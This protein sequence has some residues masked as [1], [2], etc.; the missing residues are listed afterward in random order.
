MKIHRP[1]RK[2]SVQLPCTA[3]YCRIHRLGRKLFRLRSQILKFLGSFRYRKSANFLGCASPQIKK[4]R[5]FSW[6]V[7]KFLQKMHNSVSPQIFGFVTCGTYLRTTYLAVYTMYIIKHESPK[8][9]MP[10]HCIKKLIFHTIFAWQSKCV[11]SFGTLPKFW[12]FPGSLLTFPNRT[13]HFQHF[14]VFI[15]LWPLLSS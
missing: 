2:V 7:R 5:K 9:L 8:N 15:L 6:F 3:K 14:Y 11:L 13:S 1:W 12:L 4:I 10:A